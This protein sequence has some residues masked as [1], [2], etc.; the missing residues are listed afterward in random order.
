MLHRRLFTFAAALSL[1]L[2][3]AIAALWVRSK[4]GRVFLHDGRL[5]LLYVE[6]DD[7][8]DFLFYNVLNKGGTKED[9]G[10]LQ[11]RVAAEMSDPAVWDIV[12]R[13]GTDSAGWRRLGIEFHRGQSRYDIW[14]GSH[15][16]S[17]HYTL[18]A[19]SL[20]TPAILLTVLPIMW[21]LLW[22]AGKIRVSR[23]PHLCS[24]CGYDLRVTP[25]RCPECGTVPPKR[26]RSQVGSMS[27]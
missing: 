15:P 3:L 7:L 4:M 8:A 22:K 18:V 2:C 25:D 20:S 1:L 17:L 27:M 24:I 21:L 23:R 16:Y 5:L 9:G 14:D 6:P 11:A 19:I 10:Q 13:S 26:L 12:R